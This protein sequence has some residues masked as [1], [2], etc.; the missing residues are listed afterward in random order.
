MYQALLVLSCIE[1]LGTRLAPC[2]VPPSSIMSSSLCVRHLLHMWQ[3]QVEN[4]HYSTV[5]G[6]IG[7]VISL[8]NHSRFSVSL[9]NYMH[10]KFQSHS[11]WQYSCLN[12]Y[13]SPYTNVRFLPVTRLPHIYYVYLVIKVITEK[14]TVGLSSN[15]VGLYKGPHPNYIEKINVIMTLRGRGSR[16]MTLKVV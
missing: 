1:S 15:S 7:S 9:Y 8:Q 4:E 11:Y 16:A 5:S 10:S 13:N 2:N 14:S 6:L 12:L 3:S